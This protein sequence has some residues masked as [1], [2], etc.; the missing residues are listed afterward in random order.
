MF[1]MGDFFELRPGLARI[2]CEQLG[3]RQVNVNG[4]AIHVA[5][6]TFQSIGPASERRIAWK[7]FQDVV[8][9]GIIPGER[10]ICRFEPHGIAVIIKSSTINLLFVQVV[11][12]H[13]GLAQYV[14]R[15]TEVV[16]ISSGRGVELDGF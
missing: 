2:S 10:K 3:S 15:V 5:L 8:S 4:L 7:R 6:G 13:G 1:W 16:V 11:E 14:E 12:L 9:L